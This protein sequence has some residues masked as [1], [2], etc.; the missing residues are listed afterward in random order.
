MHGLRHLLCVSC[1]ACVVVSV[2]QSPPHLRGPHR[3]D[4]VLPRTF[5]HN[6]PPTTR[7]RQTCPKGDSLLSPGSPASQ[8]ATA[9]PRADGVAYEYGTAG[10][11]ATADVLDSV[12]SHTPARARSAANVY[13]P[14][15]GDGC[16]RLV[17]TRPPLVRC[18]SSGCDSHPTPRAR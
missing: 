8:L 9:H 6:P 13:P 3:S 1:P 11:R 10:F 2:D 17:C 5:Y 14:P 4:G 7:F 16:V 18:R 15:L 12:S